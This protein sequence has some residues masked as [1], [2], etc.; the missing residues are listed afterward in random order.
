[1]AVSEPGRTLRRAQKPARWYALPR[2]RG[3]ADSAARFVSRPPPF[4]T[5]AAG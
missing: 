4:M 2:Y 1:M 5:L 3:V